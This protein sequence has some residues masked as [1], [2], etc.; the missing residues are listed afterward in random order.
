VS[1][2]CFGHAV[3]ICFSELSPSM[4]Y[5]LYFVDSWVALR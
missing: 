5:D 1:H 3:N 4:L 2:L